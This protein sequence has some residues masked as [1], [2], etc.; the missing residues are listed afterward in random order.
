MKEQLLAAITN[1]ALPSQIGSG[2]V[3]SGVGGLVVGKLVSAVI[4]GILVLAFLMAFFYLIMGGISWITGGG[5]KTQL[6]NARNK[7]THA[8]IGLIIVASVYAVMMLL[9]PWLGIGFPT[10]HIPTVTDDTT[11][12]S[13]TT[14]FNPLPTYEQSWQP[15]NN[16]VNGGPPIDTNIPR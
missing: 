5:D 4:G 14:P 6:E 8:I 1:P 13:N 11:I 2:N 16:P 15:N 3:E 7:I 10:L 12:P 9:G